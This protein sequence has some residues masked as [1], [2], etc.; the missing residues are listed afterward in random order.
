MAVYGHRYRAYDGPVAPT[1]RRFLVLT[2]YALAQLF[3]SRLFIAFFVLCF[4]APLVASIRIYFAHNAEAVAIFGL[5]P[6]L[7]EQLLAVDASFFRWWV[8]FPQSIL[9]F[10]LALAAGPTLVSPDFRNNAIPLVLS[11]PISRESYILGKL[12]ALLVPLSAITWIP[13]LALYLLQ[14]GLAGFDWVGRFWWLGPAILAASLVWIFALSVAVLAV[15]AWIRWPPIARLLIL[16]V[17]TIASGFGALVNVLLGT[18]WGSLLRWD[19]VLESLW[20]GLLR[21]PADGPR[22]SFAAAA[23]MLV[24]VTVASLALLRARVRAYEVER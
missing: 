6:S 21:L 22:L 23:T 17:P 12:L 24:V 5:Q 10:W 9:A 7:V 1:G 14:A 8:L 16:A 13:A 4:V 2:R 11:R 19:D 15:S 20:F 18:T 3:R